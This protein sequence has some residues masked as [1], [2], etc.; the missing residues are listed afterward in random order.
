MKP[1]K[2]LSSLA[3]AVLVLSLTACGGSGGE[4]VSFFADI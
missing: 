1:I 3:S 2:I 4:G